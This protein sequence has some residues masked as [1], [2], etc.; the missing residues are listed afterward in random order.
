MTTKRFTRKLIA[1]TAY[2]HEKKQ[3]ERFGIKHFR[4]LTVTVSAIRQRNLA[5]AAR[6]D[7]HVQDAR[8]GLFLFANAGELTLQRPQS[9]FEKVWTTLGDEERHAL[10]SD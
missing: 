1:Y 6:A 8:S 7:E 9:V 3:Q 4:V 10:I 2:A 5:E